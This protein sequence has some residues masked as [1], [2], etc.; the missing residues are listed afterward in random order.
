MLHLA[1][2]NGQ[3]DVAVLLIAS[4]AEVDKADQVSYFL[5]LCNLKSNTQE[6]AG[7]SDYEWNLLQQP[8]LWVD[9]NTFSEQFSITG[10]QGSSYP[11]QLPCVATHGAT[12]F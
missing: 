8:G 6:R 12:V 2:E 9:T 10:A 11:L 7:C 5:P 4:G 3:T 1:A